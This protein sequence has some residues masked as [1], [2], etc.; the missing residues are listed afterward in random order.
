MKIWILGTIIYKNNIGIK[1]LFNIK[2]D[3]KNLGI[4]GIVN[5]LDGP[6]CIIFKDEK[7]NELTLVTDHGGILNL[8]KYENNNTFSI[9]NSSLALSRTYRVSPEVN[10]IV[11]FLRSGSICNSDTIYQEIKLLEPASI[12]EFKI[13]GKPQIISKYEYWKNNS[14]IQ[15]DIQFDEASYL[16]KEIL[17]EKLNKFEKENLIFDFTSGFDSRLILSSYLSL[18]PNKNHINTFVFGPEKS[19]EVELVKNCCKNLGIKNYH[20]SLPKNW[21]EMFYE[22]VIKSFFLSDGEENIF[23]YAPILYSQEFKSKNFQYSINGLGGELY[24]DFWWLQ[25]IVCWKKPANIKRLIESR[26]LQYEYDYSIF[27]ETWKKNIININNLLFKIYNETNKGEDITNIY[28]TSQI[29][30]IYFRQKIR[31]WAGRTMSTSSQIIRSVAPLTFND[32]LDVGMVVHPK[33]KRFGRLV[34]EVVQLNSLELAK[35]KMRNGIPCENINIKNLYQFLPILTEYGKRGLRKISQKLFNKTILLDR[36]LTYDTSSWF[37]TFLK[38]K[39]VQKYIKFEN[40]FTKDMYDKKKYNIFIE[41]SKKPGF[42]YYSQLGNM[43][44][45]EMRMQKD[46]L[47]NN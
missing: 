8:Y 12:Y 37:I 2:N 13:S 42:K 9:S 15:E 29:D 41:E 32:C 25:E 47:K 44:T 30:N 31:R 24:R 21:E 39:Q 17:S 20:L 22:Y 16:L 10:G 14:I 11:Q 35:Q 38:E 23:G 40:M 27:S 18:N 7:K 43:I 28:N 4:K 33:Y 36:S 3:I 46:N 5:N 6:F 26:V 34:K 45:L 1:T 19:N